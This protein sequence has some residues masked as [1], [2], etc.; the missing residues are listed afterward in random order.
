MERAVEADLA[1]AGT[2]TSPGRELLAATRRL[3]AT[4]LYETLFPKGHG[5]YRSEK[6]RF[7]LSRLLGRI[8]IL[9]GNGNRVPL[10]PTEIA[11]LFRSE[12]E[13][14]KPVLGKL[15]KAKLAT[16]QGHGVGAEEVYPDLLALL[17]PFER[18]R[19]LVEAVKAR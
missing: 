12:W 10:D 13:K 2:R 5:E 6:S 16:C 17:D 19:L 15:G 4:G 18:E 3:V 9:H 8:W 1:E 11:D 7:D 14:R